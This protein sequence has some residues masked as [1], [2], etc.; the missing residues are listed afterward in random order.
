M[1]IIRPEKSLKDS[2]VIEPKQKMHL[3]IYFATESTLDF[4]FK[5]RKG[6]KLSLQCII[7]NSADCSLHFEQEADSTLVFDGAFA[8][9]EQ[10][11]L[12][13]NYKTIHLGQNSKSLFNLVGTLDGTAKKTSSEIIDFRAGAVNAEGSETEKVTLFSNS[14]Q[15][16]AEPIILC[17]EEN[18]HGVHSFS[19]GHLDPDAIN[20][21]RA[22]GVKLEDAKKIIS[23]EQIL[24]VAK[25]CKNEAIIQEIEEA[26]K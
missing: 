15:N 10:Q 18:M 7:L 25:L 26:L 17:A 8:L 19:S 12:N 16:V 11:K 4:R 21:L 3:V 23:R 13:F 5:L 20:Y 14:A 22:R 9:S 2:F 6:A 1:K 24:Q